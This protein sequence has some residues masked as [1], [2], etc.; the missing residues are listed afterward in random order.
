MLVLICN[1]IEYLSMH[2]L[3]ICISSLEK[4]LV[5]AFIDFLS[6]TLFFVVI[7]LYIAISFKI[8]L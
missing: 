7:V 1:D 3:V 4:W 8:V 2:F 5:M 6:W